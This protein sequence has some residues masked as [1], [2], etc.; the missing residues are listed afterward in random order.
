MWFRRDLRLGDNPAL[1][2]ASRQGPVLALFVLDP[3]LLS[4]AGRARLAFLLASLRTLDEDIRLQGGQLVVRYGLPWRV[5]PEV[6]GEAGAKSVHIS[7]D[8]G[9]YGRRRDAKVAKALAPVP[10]VATGSA[11]AV[12]PGQLLAPLGE[13]YR[14]Y[15]AFAKAWRA[16]GWPPPV[17]SRR[18]VAQ[19]AKLPGEPVPD[20][21]NLGKGL[22]LPEPGERAALE[23]W[24]RFRES[25]LATYA[26]ARDR[27][28]LDNT[29]RLS[30]Y[31]RFGQI[32]P[33]TLLAGA[34]NAAAG[35]GARRFASE[36]AWREFYAAILARWP[37]S[38]WEP[39]RPV[40]ASSSWRRDPKL[41]AAWVEGRTGYPL[42]DAGMRQ[43]KAQAWLHNR[44]RMVVASFLVKDLHLDWRLGARHFMG[45]L[46]DADLASNQHGWQ[47]VAGTGTD[48]A[49]YHRIFNP[50]LQ[51]KRFDPQGTYV[52][53]WVP[54]LQGL[55]TAQIFEPWKL[56]GGPP[57]GYPSPV[58][59]HQT[60]R[61]VA[62]SMYEGLGRHRGADV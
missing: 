21:T 22:S 4:G 55:S 58:V 47:W 15:S 19:W 14:T 34:Q 57:A 7:A 1:L 25:G 10:L 40:L 52:K 32:H 24:A 56:P 42:V 3:V 59:D 35:E 44:A 51:A 48:A 9:P 2:A 49:P 8:H 31:L 17:A 61:K 45:Q 13:P 27:L 23:A 43:L 12:S 30:A 16:R 60:E 38:A 62:L 11:Y 53:R 33:R 39:L 46:A 37:N 20:C 18:A 41:L 54:E 5:L 26:E 36:L 50:V 29:S 28:D 6:V